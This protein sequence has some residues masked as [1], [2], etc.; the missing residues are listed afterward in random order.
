MSIYSYIMNIYMPKVIITGETLDY[1]TEQLDYF[2]QEMRKYRI[3]TVTR[4]HKLYGVPFIKYSFLPALILIIVLGMIYMG[5]KFGENQWMWV[6]DKALAFFYIFG[7]GLFTLV[8][9]IAEKVTVNKLRKRLGLSKKD[10]NI[11]VI[12]FQITGMEN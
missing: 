2:E 1:T 11:L 5:S 8:S 12:A 4:L 10:F 6:V 9:W 7:F 3:P